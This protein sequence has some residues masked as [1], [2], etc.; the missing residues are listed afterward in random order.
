MSSQMS[1][2]LATLINPGHGY[3]YHCFFPYW[4]HH[5]AVS[6]KVSVATTLILPALNKS[7]ILI[8]TLVLILPLFSKTMSHFRSEKHY[9]ICFPTCLLSPAVYS[10]GKQPWCKVLKYQRYVILNVL[11]S[12]KGEHSLPC[13]NK[14]ICLQILIQN[15]LLSNDFFQS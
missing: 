5:L 7:L 13:M 10:F 1:S 2:S 12:L 15:V 8:S 9:D 3:Q 4:M 14:C 6:P 11:L